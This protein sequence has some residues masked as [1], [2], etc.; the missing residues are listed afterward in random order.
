[1]FLHYATKLLRRLL[2][3][4]SHNQHINTVLLSSTYVN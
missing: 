1:M 3:S 4:H 2:I